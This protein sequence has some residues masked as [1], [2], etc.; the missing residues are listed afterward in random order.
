MTWYFV[1][2]GL[3]ALQRLGELLWSRRNLRRQARARAAAGLPPA[4][5]AGGGTAWAVMVALHVALLVAPA[6]EVHFRGAVVPPWVAVPAVAVWALAQVLRLWTL[7]VLGSSWNARGVVDEG[8]RLVTAGP[9]RWIRHPN[10]LAVVLEFLALPA[11]A[12]AWLSWGMLNL[13]HAPVLA[14]R[15]RQEEALLA[16]VPGWR[17]AMAGKGRLLP[18]LG[19]RGATSPG[20]EGNDAAG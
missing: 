16:R 3:V 6:A 2:L 7:S 19:R 11:A 14:R 18:R 4:P 12:G 10:Y 17:E 1:L 15:I 5:R 13:L 20:G 9:Y 8:L